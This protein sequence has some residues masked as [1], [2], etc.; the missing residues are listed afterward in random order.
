MTNLKTLPNNL[1]GADK[2]GKMSAKYTWTNWSCFDHFLLCSLFQ[3]LVPNPWSTEMVL[4]PPSVPDSTWIERGGIESGE[5]EPNQQS[6]LMRNCRREESRTGSAC[7]EDYGPYK[8]CLLSRLYPQGRDEVN[9]QLLHPLCTILRRTCRS[10]ISLQP[11]LFSVL[12]RSRSTATVPSFQPHSHVP[13]SWPTW[14]IRPEA[15]WKPLLVYSFK[16]HFTDWL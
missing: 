7:S 15:A 2:G 10:I 11:T 6:K 9:Q 3:A 16:R 13:V 14:K 12:Q 8:F 4:E 1:A 5:T